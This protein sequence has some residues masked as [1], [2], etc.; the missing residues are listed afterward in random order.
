MI[1]DDFTQVLLEQIGSDVNMH[2]VYLQH[3]LS[4][5]CA[6]Y[7]WLSQK[8]KDESYETLAKQMLLR[9]TDSIKQL[10]AV[11]IENGITGIGLIVLWLNNK[12]FLTGNGHSFFETI[13]A[14]LYKTTNLGIDTNSEVIE[15][16]NLLDVLIFLAERLELESIEES[17]KQFL[18]LWS[19]KIIAYIHQRV[20][21][22]LSDEPLLSDAHYDLAI[23]LYVLF[24]L[25]KLGVYTYYLERIFNEIRMSVTTRIPYLQLNRAYLYYTLCLIG[26]EFSLGNEWVTYMQ[27]LKSSFSINAIIENEIRGNQ[28]FGQL[29]LI[30][31][32][33]ALKYYI[34]NGIEI[35]IPYDLILKKIKS[36]SY[37]KNKTKVAEVPKGL[38]GI[39]GLYLLYINIV[40]YGTKD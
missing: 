27:W 18:K 17:Y 25:H 14:Y 34:K 6:F 3:G 36:S 33:F 1:N 19:V 24:K 12:G 9:V 7:F 30:R 4:G 35:E 10:P 31:L 8:A 39:L 2:N 22:I 20:S 40:E 5:Y 16:H 11:D 15:L 26:K 23:F 28:L 29:G 37:Y 21:T 13:E 38:D 32:Y